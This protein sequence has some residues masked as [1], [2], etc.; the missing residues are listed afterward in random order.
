MRRCFQT[1]RL[2][3]QYSCGPRCH[4][5]S[6]AGSNCHSQQLL[7][8]QSA[9]SRRISTHC[10]LLPLFH[11]GWSVYGLIL[12]LTCN[13][14]FLYSGGKGEVR[15][16][17]ILAAPRKRGDSEGAPPRYDLTLRLEDR[18]L[19][20]EQINVWIAGPWT[21]WSAAE[22][23]RRRTIGLY[24]GLYK[25]FQLLEIGGA[26]SQIELMWGIGI[27]HWRKD[28]RLVDRPLLERRLDIELDDKRGGLIRI[29]PTAADAIF[30][31]K[32][33][34]E[35]GCAN[36][37]GLADLIRREIQR[38]GENEGVSPFSRDSFEPILLPA[39][40]RIDP[41][42]CYAPDA[43]SGSAATGQA[44]PTR[45]TVTDKWV[46]FARPRSQHVILQDIDRLRRAASDEEQPIKGLPERLVTEPSWEVSPTNWKPL[47]ARIGASSDS[48][49]A[50]PA[51]RDFGCVFPET[52]Q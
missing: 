16:E 7:R 15:P 46:L 18:P 38:A 48:D 22:I 37:P 34:E 10:C 2:R 24:Q 3:F 52:I 33:Y 41:E 9:L 32:P 51:R 25:V 14:G 42:G 8:C 26:E 23:P 11:S 13:Q 29:R 12:R 17:D 19:I 20:A 6:F 44:P 5:R 47:S 27:V 4:S 35:L 1:H 31:L 43:E 40:A 49:V 30:D 45:L 39:G 36:L 50:T 21:E 28:G